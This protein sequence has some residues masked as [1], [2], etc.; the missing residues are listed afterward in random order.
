MDKIKFAVLV[1]LEAAACLKIVSRGDFA[2][3]MNVIIH[4]FS[5]QNIT[6]LGSD[7]NIGN[8]E[9]TVAV[10]TPKKYSIVKYK[11]IPFQCWSG[12]FLTPPELRIPGF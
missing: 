3:N 1:C 11:K 4:L 12:K 2:T 5:R 6:D 7:Q 8:F 10:R 9:C